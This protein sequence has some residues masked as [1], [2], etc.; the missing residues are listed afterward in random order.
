MTALLASLSVAAVAAMGF[1]SQAQA[2]GTNWVEGKHYTVIPTQRTNVPA[3]KVEVLE[4]FSYGCPACNQFQPT[5]KK[6]KATLPPNAQISYLPASWHAQEDWPVFQRAFL[7][8][9]TLGV[10]DKAHDAMYGAIWNT[11]EL[12]IA[13]P[14]TRRLKTKL[15]SIEDIAR[16]Y[17]RVAGV[18]TADFLNASKSFGV[19]LKMR[20]AD[21]QISDMKVGGTPALIVNGKYRVNN[22]SVQTPDQ[23][24]EM[25]KYLVAK[26][27]AP[28][29]A[30]AKKP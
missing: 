21:R 7:T 2:Q 15:P 11:G 30:S 26:E 8:A 17:Q 16:F 5:I 10:A 25:V 12:G 20:Q 6:L 27:S 23:I 19:D 18:K 13:D 4:V 1:A 28:S 29:A 24:I 3:G 14:S 9:Q 22:E